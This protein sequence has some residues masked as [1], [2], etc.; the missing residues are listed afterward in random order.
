MNRFEI[1]AQSDGNVKEH[2][3]IPKLLQMISAGKFPRGKRRDVEILYDD[4]CRIFQGEA[5]NCNPIVQARSN[6]K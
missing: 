2:N 6:Q 5:C 1:D 3:Y 4:W